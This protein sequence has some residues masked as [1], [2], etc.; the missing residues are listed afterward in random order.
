MWAYTYIKKKEE[1]SRREGEKEQGKGE[2]KEKV[3][4]NIFLNTSNLQ[5]MTNEGI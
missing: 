1:G 2:E 5:G 4:K 3:K